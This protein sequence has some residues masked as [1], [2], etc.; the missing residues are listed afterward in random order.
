MDTA[1][2]QAEMRGTAV[3]RA[4][5]AI[6]RVSDS[7]EQVCALDDLL[8]SIAREAAG[9][10]GVRR[11][12]IHLRDEKNGLFRGCVGHE[13]DEHAD[14]YVKRS[15]AGTPGDG[16]TLELLRSKQPVIIRDA[17]N[18]PRMIKSMA[19]FSRIRSMMAVPVIVGGE[20][21]GVIYLDDGQQPHLF[22]SE[23][24]EMAVV[25]ARLAS[26]AVSHA[27][28]RIEL[29]SRLDT[30]ERQIKMLRQTAAVEQQLSDLVL[31]ERG[32]EA[33]V[34]TLAR[35]L[36]KP[37]AVYDADNTALAIAACSDG[38]DGML[39][40]LLAP[41]AVDHPAVRSALA[42]GGETRPYLVS[43]MPEAGIMH[44]HLVAPVNV[45]GELWARL[46]VMEHRAR[47]AGSD[48]LTLRRAATLV[49]L[50]MRIERSAM[51]ADSDACSS[52]AAELL[53]GPSDQVIVERR[54]QRLGVKLDVPHVV[55]LIGSDAQRG[56]AAGQ[57]RAVASEFKDLCPSLN[58]H[59]TKMQA[60]VAAMM[61]VPD[62]LDAATF[63]S[64]VK[65]TLELV[66][67]RL[68]G[69]ERV[70]AGISTVCAA[71]PEYPEAYREAE[72]V[73]ECIRRFGG[74]SGPAVLSA[75][76][77]GAGRVFLATSDPESVR[78]FAQAKFGELISDASKNDLV[79]TLCCFFENTASIRRCAVALGVHENTIR[80]RLARIDE[81]TGLSVTHDPDDQ[82]AA[83]L[84][85][86]VLLL[87]G[88]L[89]SYESPGQTCAVNA[90]AQGSLV[91]V[92]A[93]TG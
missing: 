81:L 88:R 43:P 49:A 59:T 19:R 12:S 90:E 51:E 93:L 28:S 32:L 57:F 14:D 80:Y 6:C 38:T 34:Q 77:L 45:D 64:Q 9:L 79:A 37:C 85:M 76:D 18:D 39:P 40:R 42:G 41:P 55:A 53:S 65:A 7:L 48:M 11:C 15:F 10:M 91:L 67:L 21:V 66:C 68:T 50:H 74:N 25:F 22:T 71:A 87:Q 83:R 60:G 62:D 20:V 78:T 92:E 89:Q 3:S 84:S 61:Q 2:A 33:L 23:E 36:G 73:L 24:A 29:R 86:L 13:S 75:S 5:G 52:L 56:G 58:V 26:L 17:R 30:A 4:F 1:T 72:Q 35:L 69:A 47:F 54:A 31:A 27:Q 63:L 8:R 44:R 82:L 16:V 46:V 70:A